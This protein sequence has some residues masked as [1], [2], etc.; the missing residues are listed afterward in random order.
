MAH[1]VLYD[2]VCGLCNRIVQFLL[3]RDRKDQFLFAPL[4]SPR[5]EGELARLGLHQTELDTFYLIVDFQTETERLLSK[6][7]AALKVLWIVGGLWRMT[8]VFS[9]LP[10]FVLDAAYGF[11]ARRRY[12]WFGRYDTCP[13][14]DAAVRRKF[15]DSSLS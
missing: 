14:P 12:R 15:L 7:R 1:L 4:Q 9:I 8:A 11:I 5:G 6:G 2:G 10:T 13:M 3:K